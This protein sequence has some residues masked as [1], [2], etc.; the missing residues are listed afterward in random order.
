MIPIE[1]TPHNAVIFLTCGC[2]AQ[3]MLDHPTGAAF[4]VQVFE[5]CASHRTESARVRAVSRGELVSPF[6]RELLRSA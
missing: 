5:P 3:R 1:K 4:L 2:A 6:T